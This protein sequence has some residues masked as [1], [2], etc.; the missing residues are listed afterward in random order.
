MLHTSHTQI[1]SAA[2]KRRPKFVDVELN[3]SVFRLPKCLFNFIWFCNTRNV[4]FHFYFTCTGPFWPVLY[5][6]NIAYK[7]PTKATLQEKLHGKAEKLYISCGVYT[8]FHGIFHGIIHD[9]TV[10]FSRYFIHGHYAQLYLAFALQNSLLKQVRVVKSDR[11]EQEKLHPTS[12]VKC[13]NFSSRLLETKPSLVLL[14]P[15]CS[16]SLY[17]MMESSL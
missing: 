11:T 4:R 2:R 14:P 15:F 12:A 6:Q 8:R 5:T 1:Q 7:L 10:L 3:T 13:L 17:R 16:V 9:F